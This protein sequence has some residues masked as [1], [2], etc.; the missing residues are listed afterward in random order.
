MV[1]IREVLNCKPGKVGELKKRFRA[2]SDV[3]EG[4]GFGRFRL[5]TDVSGEPFWTLIAEMEAE[6]V[7]AFMQMEE[8][9]MANPDARKAMEGYHDFVVKGRREIY[10]IE[11]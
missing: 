6:S 4:L 9:T 1:L 7:D 11:N 2:L 8:K 10:R 5:L 3:T